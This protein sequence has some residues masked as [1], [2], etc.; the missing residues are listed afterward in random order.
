MENTFLNHLEWRFAVKE[1][2]PNRKVLP[3]VLAKI[4]KATRFAPSSFGL[5]PYHIF[6]VSNEAL[7]KKLREKGY[8]QPK[9]TQ[10]SHFFVFCSR[11]DLDSRIDKY[12]EMARGDD[13]EQRKALEGYEGMMRGSTAAKSAEDLKAWADRQTYIALGFA[14]A[15]C[16]E[17]GVDS[18]PMEGFDPS[19][20]D[21]ILNVPAHMHSVVCMAIGY[22]KAD[23]ERPKIRYPE[24][25]LFTFL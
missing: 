25:D 1:L 18:G 9:I 22:R 8:D 2:D 11:T 3:D 10:G 15:A 17:L 23:P 4:V 7:Q 14:L 12:V 20:Y 13:A 6:V 21:K 16:A 19:A 5:Q 24:S